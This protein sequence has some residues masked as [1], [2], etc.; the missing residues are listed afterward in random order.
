MALCINL[1]CI[2][3]VSRL[4]YESI[5]DTPL[6]VKENEARRDGR[7]ED[8]SN[9]LFLSYDSSA[10]KIEGYSIVQCYEYMCAKG[11]TV[12]KMIDK[13]DF[14][15]QDLGIKFLVDLEQKQL[16]IDFDFATK[17]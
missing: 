8:K 3:C 10:Y 6:S 13:K 2:Q 1:L 16:K 14:R 4:S 11:K 9:T 17:K 5:P 12:C 15:K 7:R